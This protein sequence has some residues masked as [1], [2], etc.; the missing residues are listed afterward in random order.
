MKKK[1]ITFGQPLIL[2]EEIK[3]VLNCLKSG[4]IGTGPRVTKFEKQFAKLKKNNNV[5]A[6]N[7]CTAAL[8]LS[9]LALNLN[10]EDEVITSALTFCSTVNAIIHSGARPVIADVEY[11]SQNIDPKKIEEKITSKT[12]AII[13]VHFAGRPCNM[14]EILFLV[15][16]YKL[17]LIEDCAHAIESSYNGINCGNFGDY[18]CFSFY[19]TKNVTTGEGGMIISNSYKKISNIKILAL[20]GMSKDAWKRYSDKGYLHYDVVNSGFKYNMMDLQAAIGIHQLKKIHI[21]HKKREKIWNTYNYFFK[22][23]NIGIP[24]PIEKNTKHAYHLYTLQI[25]K[26]KCGISRNEFQKILQKKNIGTGIHYQAIPGYSFYK[27]KFGWNIEEYP[28]AKKIGS[29]TISI[30][31][32]PK[33]KKAE[34]KKIIKVVLNIFKKKYK[35]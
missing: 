8:H 12:K 33:Y 6:V 23:L 10:N 34:I 3:E 18:G 24:A 15:K 31:I 27:K 9:L 22:N 29:E 17:Y 16:K 14:K 25:N 30:P 26:E 28:N 1:F 32:S 2:N 19:A 35:K 4:W 7:S 13:I 5:A 21:N 20:H 11:N